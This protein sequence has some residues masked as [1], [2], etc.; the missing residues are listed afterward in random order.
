MPS[1]DSTTRD[2]LIQ[3]QRNEITEHEIY[4]RLARRVRSPENR[5]VL[6]RIGE[7]EKSHYLIWKKLTGI[8]PGPYRIKVWFYCL[9]GRVL[10][11]T[12]A[13]KLMEN[14]EEGAQV[15]YRKLEDTVPEAEAIRASE[16]EHENALL[17]ML[18]EE[19][20]RYVGS[21]VLG[22]SDAL[23]ELTGA[24]AGLTLALSDA[25][26]IALTGSIT[27]IAAALSMASSEYLSTKSESESGT[28]SP[29]KAAVYTGFAYLTTV[30]LLIA[31][32]LVFAN[33]LVS[34]GVTLTIAMGF[35]VK[36]FFGVEL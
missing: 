9:L 8:E 22:I 27:G 6:L 21:I 31:P 11:L 17:D 13:V 29:L 25:R 5:K 14:G 26:L 24:L 19:R 2:R 7:E 1:L 18:D 10:G 15:S 3:A 33:Y 34:L 36:H 28:K 20:L 12:F 35:V 23:V 32:Y 16:N 4:T 30:I